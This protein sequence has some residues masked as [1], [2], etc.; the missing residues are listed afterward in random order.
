MKTSL[1]FHNSIYFTF[2]IPIVTIFGEGKAIYIVSIQ[3]ARKVVVG[4]WGY[5]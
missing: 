4:G 1:L 5:N 2:F 3:V